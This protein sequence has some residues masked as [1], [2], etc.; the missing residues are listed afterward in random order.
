MK[1]SAR[2]LYHVM[3]AALS[4]AIALSLPF[5]ISFAAKNLLVY[6]S[7]I[8]NEKIFLVFVEM[9][10]ATMVIL[11]SNIIGR[12]WKDRKLSN[13]AKKAGL[14]FV[15]STR[16]FLERR[17]MKNLKERVGFA[18]DVM[19][20]GSTGFRTCVD[21]K[22]DLHQVIQHCREARIMFLNPYSDA[23]SARAKSILNPEITPDKLVEQIKR[24]IDFLK[25]LKAVQKNI[26]LKLYEDLPLFKLAII[27]DYLWVQHYHAGLD[28]QGMPEYVFRHDQNTGSLYIPFYQYFLTRWNTPDIPEYDLDSDELIYRDPAGNQ[29]RR[30]NFCEIGVEP[31]RGSELPND[32][33]SENHHQEGETRSPLLL[34]PLRTCAPAQ[35]ILTDPRHL[36]GLR[37]GGSKYFLRTSG[38]SMCETVGWT[39]S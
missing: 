19:I 38:R 6:W 27:G 2:I 3:V 12:S 4:A 29:V 31:A 22:G 33:G 35:E 23:A 24:S 18:R 39:M 28:V 21:P 37:I 10:V 14:V 8:G 16:S 5:T 17:R 36:R 30:K 20:I 11:L 25:G 26:R 9:T 1:G 13:M 34:P 32:P 7:F 15:S